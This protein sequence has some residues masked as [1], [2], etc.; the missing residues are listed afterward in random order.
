M[1]ASVRSFTTSYVVA[2][3]MTVA[4]LLLTGVPTAMAAT[5]ASRNCNSAYWNT[6]ER[7][8]SQAKAY[9]YIAN[10]DGYEWGGGC[11]DGDGRDDTPGA[12]DSSGEGPDCSGFV[13]KTWAIDNQWGATTKIFRVRSQWYGAHGPYT[14]SGFKSG[15]DP[16]FSVRSKSRLANMDALASTWHIGL[17]R[18]RSSSTGRAYVIE[19]KSDSAGVIKG[20]TNYYQS[21]SYSGVTRAYWYGG[22]YQ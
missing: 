6:W 14:A 1:S 15:D 10:G 20:Y 7:T 3:L 5:W 19:A 2:S 9:A 8:R 17:Y 18:F 22:N 16:K 21:S 11:W 4:L 12:P 13:F